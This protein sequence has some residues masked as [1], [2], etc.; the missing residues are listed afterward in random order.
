M[1]EARPRQLDGVC[2]M[3]SQTGGSNRITKDCCSL[4]FRYE[5]L[6]LEALIEQRLRW[7]GNGETG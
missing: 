4:S 5:G 2:M 6:F 3:R 1:G 7:E